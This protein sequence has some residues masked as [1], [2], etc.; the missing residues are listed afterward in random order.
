MLVYPTELDTGGAVCLA[1]LFGVT[2]V[3]G[4]SEDDK[5]IANA[6]MARFRS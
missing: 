6:V 3:M 2:L 4:L 5:V 1:V